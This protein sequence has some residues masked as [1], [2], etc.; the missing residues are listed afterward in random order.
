MCL[1]VLFE[2]YLNKIK[3]MQ[4]CYSM[5]NFTVYHCWNLNTVDTRCYKTEVGI[6][7]CSCYEIT[8]AVFVFFNAD[9]NTFVCIKKLLGYT[10]QRNVFFVIL[11]ELESSIT[12]LNQHRKIFELH[13]HHP[14]SSTSTHSIRCILSHASFSGFFIF[15]LF[16]HTPV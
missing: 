12:V 1:G 8:T 14:S 3:L 2:L 13:L 11:V 10:K 4:G 9:I 6:G 5:K 15:I 7:M 16:A